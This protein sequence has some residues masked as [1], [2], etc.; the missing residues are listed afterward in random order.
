MPRPASTMEVT[1]NYRDTNGEIGRIW[2]GI[3]SNEPRCTYT[4]SYIKNGEEEIGVIGVLTVVSHY[5]LGAGTPKLL[6]VH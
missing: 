4:Q 5:P 3:I 1:A 6:G 2:A